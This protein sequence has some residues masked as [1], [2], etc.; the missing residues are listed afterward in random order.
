M[1]QTGHW[2]GSGKSTM[3]PAG[4][5][6]LGCTGCCAVIIS[7]IGRDE[8]HLP[9]RAISV[10]FFC[11]VALPWGCGRQRRSTAPSSSIPEGG[12]RSER[13]RKLGAPMSEILDALFQVLKWI[14]LEEVLVSD[15]FVQGLKAGQHGPTR[16]QSDGL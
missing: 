10:G 7:R 15:R 2:R 1:T 5:V 6:V 8:R 9:A 3:L 12:L 13:A 14:P 11:G 16:P 4:V